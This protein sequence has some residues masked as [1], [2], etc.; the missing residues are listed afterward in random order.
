MD[1]NKAKQ[2]ILVINKLDVKRKTTETEL[3]ISEYYELGLGT[4]IGISAKK[5]RNIEE[6]EDKIIDE[7]KKRID[8]HPNH[9]EEK[10]DIPQHKGI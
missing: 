4:V 8:A 9:E 5:E 7:A 10:V 6:L 3:A 1:N 2:T